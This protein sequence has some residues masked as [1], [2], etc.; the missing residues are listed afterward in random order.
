MGERPEW[1]RFALPLL[2]LSLVISIIGSVVYGYLSSEIRRETQRTLAVIAE[3]KRQQIEGALHTTRVDA[4]LYFSRHS[5]LEMLF[6]QWLDGKRTDGAIRARMQDLMADLVRIRG[7]NSI[8]LL[9]GEGRPA[10]A[11]G[12]ADLL[13]QRER[14]KDILR[15]PRIEL[16]DLHRDAR[17]QVIYG[18]LAPIGGAGGAPRM[19]GGG[20]PYGRPSACVKR[21]LPGAVPSTR[22]R[23]SCA[24]AWCAEHSAASVVGVCLPP[25][26]RA[27]RWCTST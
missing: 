1:L 2:A 6:A 24:A 21:S 7:W 17:G 18:L 16:V 11:V 25:L 27:I 8:A 20:S 23:P 13:T 26:A 5:Q 9:D 19:R 12:E 22:I 15:D 4:S 3:Q 10:L 14:A